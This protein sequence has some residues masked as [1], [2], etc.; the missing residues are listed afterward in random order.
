MLIQRL[1]KEC[2][3]RSRCRQQEKRRSRVARTAQPHRQVLL[4]RAGDRLRA[5]HILLLRLDP[6]R[7]QGSPVQPPQF[8][9]HLCDESEEDRA[10]V[11]AEVSMLEV[12]SLVVQVQ[13]SQM[14]KSELR[15]TL[16]C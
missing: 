5:S 7:E 15:H 8:S 14:N 10:I 16:Y 6:I 11:L 2:K 4:P 1:E 3:R 9:P 12:F 13:G